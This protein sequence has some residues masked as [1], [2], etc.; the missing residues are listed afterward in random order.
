M[1]AGVVWPWV[2]VGDGTPQKGL[3][4]IADPANKELG[5]G[6]GG[7]DPCETAA[8]APSTRTSQLEQ[9]RLPG[10]RNRSLPCPRAGQ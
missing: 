7:G 1:W 8:A 2:F 10:L 6:G 9:L 3:G 4:D 5:G